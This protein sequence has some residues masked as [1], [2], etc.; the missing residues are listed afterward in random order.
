MLAGME[1]EGALRDAESP[2]GRDG[3]NVVGFDSEII[4]DLL[5]RHRGDATEE[6]GEGAFVLGVEMLDEDKAQARVGRQMLEQVGEGLQ[7]AS[8]SADAD[9]RKVAF[10]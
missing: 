8:G 1:L 6:L 4:R 2:V 7:S 5:D 9:D 10:A 3:I